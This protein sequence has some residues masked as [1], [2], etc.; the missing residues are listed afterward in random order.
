LSN[1]LEILLPAQQGRNEVPEVGLVLDQH[2]A[3]PRRRTSS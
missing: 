2:D 1:H 3:G